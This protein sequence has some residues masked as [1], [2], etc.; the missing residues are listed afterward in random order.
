MTPSRG[1][2][3]SV[4]R[5]DPDWVKDPV[6]PW[7]RDLLSDRVRIELARVHFEF[8]KRALESQLE[9]VNQVS[10]I[11]QRDLKK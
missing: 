3:P 10:E 5:F 6:P 1:D 11:V 9:L 8:A 2:L 7:L 4:L